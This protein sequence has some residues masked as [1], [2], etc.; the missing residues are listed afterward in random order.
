MSAADGTVPRISSGRVRAPWLAVYPPRWAAGRRLDLRRAV[1]RQWIAWRAGWAVRGRLGADQDR[2][3]AQTEK[4]GA[5]VRRM[6][7][8]GAK[9]TQLLSMV[10]FERMSEREAPVRPLGTLPGERKPLPLRSVRRVIEQD[11]DARLPDV[12][13][14]F[15]EEPFAVASLGQVHRARTRD[16]EHV[17]V[18]VQQPDIADAIARELRNIGLVRPVVKHLAPGSDATALLTEVRERIGDELDYEIEARQQR[19]LARLFRGRPHVRVP[20][21]HTDLST[22]RVLVTEYVDGLALDEIAQLDEAERDRIGEIVFRFYFGLL[23]REGIVAGDPHPDNCLLCPDGRV[24]LLDFAL[25]RALEPEYLNGEREIMRAIVAV[26]P[27]AVRSALA[28]LGYLGKGQSYDPVALLEHLATAGEWLLM[29]GFRRIDPGYVRRTLELGYPP[30]SPWFSLL[31]RMRLPP[32]TLLLRRMELQMLFLLGEL[33]AGGDWAAI[34]A[35]HWAGQPP[36]TPLGREDAAFF[37]G[38]SS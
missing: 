31:R 30:H 15:D 6:G 7:G 23:W 34:A 13:A 12:F 4:L 17:A 27:D 38:P 10:Q 16:G 19:R 5:Q 18:K 28:D 11:L 32:P 1:A 21:V 8:A 22:S 20:C 24:C 29:E 3:V 35:E 26:D 36:S 14:V 9:I 37:Q 2:I 25:L 33:R